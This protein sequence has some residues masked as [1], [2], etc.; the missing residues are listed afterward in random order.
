MEGHKSKLGPA[1]CHR[2]GHFCGFHSLPVAQGLDLRLP[3][4]GADLLDGLRA[5]DVGEYLVV[6]SEIEVVLGADFNQVEDEA[7][8]LVEELPLA[9]LEEDLLF[10][11]E[12]V[13]PV[14][15]A[16]EGVDSDGV[17]TKHSVH[18]VDED[19]VGPQS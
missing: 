4:V 16:G 10:F 17:E 3:E 12:A 15:L 1:A 14:D 9:F 2:G 13:T 11:G 18:R 5:I 7:F 6:F 19:A 8:E